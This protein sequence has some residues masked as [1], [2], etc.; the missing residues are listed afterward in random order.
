MGLTAVGPE[1]SY[2]NFNEGTGETANVVFSPLP[3]PFSISMGSDEPSLT[4]EQ[5]FQVHV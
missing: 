3:W 1:P 4:I 5:I 2:T